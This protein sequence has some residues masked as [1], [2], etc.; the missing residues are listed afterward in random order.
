[1]F[2]YAE[3]YAGKGPNDVLLCLQHYFKAQPF[4][5]KK[6]K[7]FANNCFSQNKNRH[8]I[9]F[10]HALVHNSRIQEV[11]IYY[12]LPGHCRMPCDQGFGRT[13]RR[14]RKKDKVSLPSEWVELVKKTDHQNLFTIAYVEHPLTDDMHDDGTAVVQVHDYKRAF[15]SLLRAPKGISTIRGLKFVQGVAPRCRY[16]MTGACDTNVTFL[17]KGHKIKSLVNAINPLVLRRAYQS[18]LPIKAAKL[19]DV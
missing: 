9:A 8:L 6:I 4:E 7:L 17:K 12:P 13:E 19:A 2:L 3:N 14:R 1:M 5:I 18:F 15:D 16:S 10:F 11:S